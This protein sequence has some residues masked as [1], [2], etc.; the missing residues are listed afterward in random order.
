V[1]QS[2]KK[3]TKSRG[4]IQLEFVSGD[5]Y[6]RGSNNMFIENIIVVGL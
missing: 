2:L 1:Y 3:L 6:T 4:L 5:L